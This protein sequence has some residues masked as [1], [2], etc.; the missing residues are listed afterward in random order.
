MLKK[1]T[2]FCLAAMASIFLYQQTRKLPV[3]FWFNSM[4]R[5]E[6]PLLGELAAPM[7]LPLGMLHT[8]SVIEAI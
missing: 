7:E 2:A 4:F 6:V 3:S 5:V 8:G 1:S